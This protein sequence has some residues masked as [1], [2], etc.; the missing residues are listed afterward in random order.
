[1]Q[2]HVLKLTKKNATDVS[3]ESFAK[4]EKVFFST[5]MRNQHIYFNC[6]ANGSYISKAL[7]GHNE[8]SECI[9]F[10]VKLNL[11]SYTRIL[12]KNS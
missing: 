11:H 6:T 7:I 3:P 1:M 5:T 9:L 2:L 8:F 4:I 12:L 10:W